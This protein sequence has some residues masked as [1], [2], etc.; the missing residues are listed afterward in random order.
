MAEAESIDV[1]GESN[2]P[3]L[4][5]VVD[6][7]GNA[8]GF[9]HETTKKIVAELL[10]K[11]VPI[12]GGAARFV[13]DLPS[14]AKAIP[15]ASSAALFFAHGD[16][17]PNDSKTA[18]H[19]WIGSLKTFWAHLSTSGEVL[20]DMLAVLC[21]CQGFNQDAIDAVC[22][23]QVGAFLFVAPTQDLLKTEA[24]AF[25]PPFFTRIS[26]ASRTQL[27]P[28]YVEALVKE[29]NHLAGG[30]MKVHRSGVNPPQSIHGER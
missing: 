12:A 9:E 19:F 6:A 5:A 2:K 15:A 30:K 22:H 4:L 16:D 3:F 18:Q 17:P 14:I 27:T 8:N 25:F 24:E 29:L 20:S 10:A 1:T 23:S 26:Q 11:K 7:T 28:E 13:K 21:V